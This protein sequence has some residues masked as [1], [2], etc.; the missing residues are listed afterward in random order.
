MTSG[1]F[2]W[3]NNHKNPNLEKLDRVLVYRTWE[4]LFPLA[5][6]HKIPRNDS[7]HNSLVIKLN[8]EH[9]KPIK[10]L[11]Y[12]LFWRNEEDFLKRVKVAWEK[13]VFGKDRL[14]V[15]LLRLKNVKNSLKGRGIN[16]RGSQLRRKKE[17]I[18]G[19]QDI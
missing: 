10:N 8:N 13:L 11:I 18:L 7:D 17:I 15:F 16:L 4:M 12:E 19:L 6:V 1:L 9:A 5:M 2:T 3:S 14:S